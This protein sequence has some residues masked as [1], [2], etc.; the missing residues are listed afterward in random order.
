[1]LSIRDPIQIYGHRL[2]VRGWP[3]IFCTNANQKKAGVAIL[4]ID[5]NI[6]I[7]T[8][9]KLHYLMIKGSIKEEGITIVKKMHPTFEHLN[10]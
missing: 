8:G 9:E 2:K 5:F 7:I 6:K 3:V 1:M 4:K 10:I